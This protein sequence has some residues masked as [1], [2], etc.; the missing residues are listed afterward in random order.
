MSLSLLH[1]QKQNNA[2]SAGR[3]SLL[4]A[5]GILLAMPD[6]QRPI[7]GPT[8]TC[9]HN[10]FVVSD[11]SPQHK[12]KYMKNKATLSIDWRAFVGT[13]SSRVT[14]NPHLT[15]RWPFGGA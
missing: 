3:R 1:G 15:R 13:H 10:L 2:S 9:L 6:A 12:R 14:V 8:D 5:T 4:F 11:K 7:H